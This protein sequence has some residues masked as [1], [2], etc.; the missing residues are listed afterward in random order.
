V[1]WL[2]ADGPGHRG[3]FQH[4]LGHD[5]E[6]ENPG[7]AGRGVE[8]LAQDARERGDEG[9]ADG[10]VVDGASPRTVTTNAR[11]LAATP[12]GKS[13]LSTGSSRIRP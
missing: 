5:V 13:R 4:R 11:C 7:L 12:P 1:P 3:A 10:L 6:G 2:A 9:I 8:L